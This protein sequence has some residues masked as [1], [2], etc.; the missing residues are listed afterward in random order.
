[1]VEADRCNH[2]LSQIRFLCVFRARDR[3][4]RLEQMVSVSVQEHIVIKL[5]SGH[6]LFQRHFPILGLWTL[7]FAKLLVRKFYKNDRNFI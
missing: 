1:M 5:G 6:I 2:S 7:K 3:K 4:I